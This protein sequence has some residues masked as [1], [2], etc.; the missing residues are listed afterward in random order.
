MSTEGGQTDGQNETN[1]PVQTSFAGGIKNNNGGSGNL[2]TITINVLYIDTCQ[3]NFQFAKYR[4]P[5]WRRG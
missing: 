3:R 2:N 4:T 5:R 1:I